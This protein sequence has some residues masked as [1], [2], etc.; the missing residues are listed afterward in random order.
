MIEST[1]YGLWPSARSAYYQYYMRYWENTSIN[2]VEESKLS[3]KVA[4]I[5]LLKVGQ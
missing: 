5:A 2:G 1:F 4:D 3:A